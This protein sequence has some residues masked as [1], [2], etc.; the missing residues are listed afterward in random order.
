MESVSTYAPNTRGYAD[1]FQ[2]GK[3]RGL[4]LAAAASLGPFELAS[5]Y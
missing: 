5:C 1:M 2:C 3:L 4:N